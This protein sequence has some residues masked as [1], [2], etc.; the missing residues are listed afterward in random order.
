MH[1]CCQIH[2]IAINITLSKSKRASAAHKYVSYNK[3]NAVGGI[4]NE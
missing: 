1:G 3:D 2:T 4:S